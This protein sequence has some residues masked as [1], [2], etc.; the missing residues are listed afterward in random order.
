MANLVASLVNPW[1]QAIA[2][3]GPNACG[4][5]VEAAASG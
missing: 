1:R 3:S 4:A 2:G 5:A